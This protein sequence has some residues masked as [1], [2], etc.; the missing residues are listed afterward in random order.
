M[1]PVA[2]IAASMAASATSLHPAHS[3]LAGRWLL[4]VNHC[5]HASSASAGDLGVGNRGGGV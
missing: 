1:R 3:R 5:H 2:S 4:P